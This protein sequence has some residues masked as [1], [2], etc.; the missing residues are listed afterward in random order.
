MSNKTKAHIGIQL[1]ALVF[2]Y[3][4]TLYAVV[5]TYQWMFWGQ[6]LD[7]LRVFVGLTTTVFIGFVGIAHSVVEAEL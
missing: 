1:A 5:N 7:D 4:F 6:P 3:P 2:I